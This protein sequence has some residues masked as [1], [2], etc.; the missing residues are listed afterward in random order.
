MFWCRLCNNNLTAFIDSP[1]WVLFSKFYYSSA[2]FLKHFLFEHTH[3]V[4]WVFS[5]KHSSYNFACPN[6]AYPKSSCRYRRYMFTNICHINMVARCNVIIKR[7]H[8]ITETF[9]CIFHDCS[10]MFHLIMFYVP[11]LQKRT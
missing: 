9:I 8:Y 11:K 7:S 6:I 10:R 1:F 4:I 5:F 2:Y 3:F